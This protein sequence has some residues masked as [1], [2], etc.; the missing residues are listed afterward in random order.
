MSSHCEPPYPHSFTP[1]SHGLSLTHLSSTPPSPRLFSRLSLRLRL[2]KL[3]GPQRQKAAFLT[4]L[5]LCSVF[6]PPLV[7]FQCVTVWLSVSLVPTAW[8][9]VESIALFGVC[10]LQRECILQHPPLPPSQLPWGPDPVHPSWRVL[11][12]VWPQR[13]WGRY[14]SHIQT[15]SISFLPPGRP[16]LSVYKGLKIN[17]LNINRHAAE[18]W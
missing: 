8:Q 10:L 13:R 5:S 17:P 15:D 9:P 1:S 4:P 2:A 7:V 14:H 16:F 6:F 12:Q 3:S 18:Q 11:P